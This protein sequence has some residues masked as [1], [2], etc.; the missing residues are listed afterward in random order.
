MNVF[1]AIL[2]FH[3][4]IKYYIY[5]N[6]P[7]WVDEKPTQVREGAFSFGNEWN[8]LKMSYFQ[9]LRVNTFQECTRIIS[10][11]AVSRLYS[12]YTGI[13]SCGIGLK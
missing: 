1:Y 5:V 10:L 4:N 9:S 6:S 7:D 12:L 11:V 2:T 13:F 3:L 8:L